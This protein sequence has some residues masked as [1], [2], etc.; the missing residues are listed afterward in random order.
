MSSICNLS[1]FKPFSL[2]LHNTLH[3]QP[4][5]A[6]LLGRV[7][8]PWPPLSGVLSLQAPQA[9]AALSHSFHTIHFTSIL[10]ALDLLLHVDG[11]WCV[12]TTYILTYISL[13]ILL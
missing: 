11:S 4:W 13:M 10:G 8:V 9:L 7:L 2:F 3:K 6:T 5:C 12:S 1:S